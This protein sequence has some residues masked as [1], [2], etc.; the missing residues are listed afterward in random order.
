MGN[1]SRLN[2]SDK[3]LEIDWTNIYKGL[4]ISTRTNYERQNF[5]G[6]L[7]KYCQFY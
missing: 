6:R 5:K 3:I 1:Y 2:S 7:D 4:S